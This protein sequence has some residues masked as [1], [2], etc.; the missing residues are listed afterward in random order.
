MNHLSNPGK[1]KIWQYPFSLLIT[2]VSTSLL[3][4]ILLSGCSQGTA[5]TPGGPTVTTTTTTEPT[6]T[7]TITTAPTATNTITTEPTI[8]LISIRMLNTNNGWALTRQSILLTTDGGLHWRDVSPANLSG[9]VGN[10]GVRDGA[11]FDASTAWVSLDTNDGAVQILRTSDDGQH[12][13]T[14]LLGN[15][16]PDRAHFVN[17]QDGWIEIDRGAAMGSEEVDIYQTTN[18]GQTWNMVSGTGHTGNSAAGSLPFSGDKT[19]ISFKDTTTG[20]ATGYSAATNFTWLYVT[21]DGGKTWQHQ[22]LPLPQ[23]ISNV[24]TTTPPVFFGNTGFLPVTGS[25]RD[26]VLYVTHD[27]GITWKST[28]PLPINMGSFSET[29]GVYV[30]DVNHTWVSD[31]NTFYSTLD[32]GQHWTTYTLPERH[33]QHEFH[34]EYDRLGHWCLC[35]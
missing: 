2:V 1:S 9:I 20:W 4:M 32:G 35:Y 17:A 34:L 19:G 23:G 30:F 11:F 13:E 7:N 24:G 31:G 8:P 27:G 28:T 18:G 5:T 15:G 12:W 22:D 16:I 26:E 10:Q 33:F 29:N 21:H 3:I 14:T 25:Q 6:A